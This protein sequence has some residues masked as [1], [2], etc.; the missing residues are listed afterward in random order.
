MMN[1]VLSILLLALPM[2]VL[3]QGGDAVR[4]SETF[5]KDSQYY[6]A[7]QVEITGTLTI[8][9]KE[10]QASPQSLKIAGKS[11][12]KYDERI[13]QVGA[14]RRVERTVRQYRQLEF[15]RKVGDDDQQS[16]LRPEAHRLVIL[17]H[18]QYEVP[19]CP[20]G[21]LTWG[22]IELVRTDVFVPALQGLLP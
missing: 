3:A 11:A 1:R 18:N 13:L 5:A 9:G 17:R 6:V 16:K 8:P 2:P 10:K 4:L 20:A 21:P 14:D 12:I 19:F 15:E 22:E 7:C